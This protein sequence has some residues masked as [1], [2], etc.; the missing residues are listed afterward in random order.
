MKIYLVSYL[1]KSRKSGHYGWHVAEA[2]ARNKKDAIKMTRATIK[3]IY[4]C[5][6]FRCR[7]GKGEKV[8][9]K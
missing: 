6:A 1:I 2:K 9:E 8:I 5:Y 7:A 3:T 4:G